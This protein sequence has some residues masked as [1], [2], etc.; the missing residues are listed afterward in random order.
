[1]LSL[2]SLFYIGQA[3]R[4]SLLTATALAHFIHFPIPAISP[5]SLVSTLFTLGLISCRHLIFDVRSTVLC[6]LSSHLGSADSLL[7]LDLN[8]Y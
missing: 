1:M 8:G 6:P 5:I 4:V 2:Q 3:R 7:G